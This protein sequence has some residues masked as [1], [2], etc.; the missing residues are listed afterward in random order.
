MQRRFRLSFLVL[1]AI[2]VAFPVASFAV[3]FILIPTSVDFGSQSIRK[4]SAAQSIS[5]VDTGDTDLTVSSIS[6]S[7]PHFQLVDGE[8]P[9]NIR[10]SHPRAVYSLVFAPD[11]VASFSGMFTIT[12]DGYAPVSVPLSGTGID[13]N[14]VIQISPSTITFA[15]QVAGTT[16][17]KQPVTITNT[18]TDPVQVLSVTSSS[19]FFLQ[20]GFNAPV[21]LNPGKT[22]KLGMRFAPTAETSY[23][24]V[25]DVAYDLLPDSGVSL[26]GTGTQPGV[27]TVTSP[28]ALPAA[29][30]G[31]AYLATLTAQPGGG[32]LSWV[33]DKA[34]TLPTGLSL[35]NAG[36]ISGT[37]DASVAT[38]NYSFTARVRDSVARTFASKSVT[39]PVIAP[40]GANCSNISVDVAGTS[41]P[42]L[43]LTDLGT[44]TYLGSE[45][46]LYPDGTNVRPAD[47]DAAGISLANQIQP[48]DADGNPDP[49][50][51]EAF[52]LLGP[53]FASEVLSTFLPIASADPA[54]NPA[55]VIVD[56]ALPGE[57]IE[58]IANPANEYW[59][60]ILNYLIPNAGVTA[61]Q[62]QAVWTDEVLA[63][64]SGV[65][66]DDMSD[67]LSDLRKLA[68]DIHVF[69]PNAKLMY[70]S[71]R[72]YTGYSLGVST[73]DP[74]P[75]AYESGFAVKWTIEDQLDGDP[76]LNFDSTR[77]PVM[78]PWLA[79]GPYYWT[80]GLLGRADG[81]TASCDDYRDDG[82][83]PSDVVG[84]VKQS[85][86]LIDF[87]KS[88]TTTTPWYLAH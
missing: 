66:P 83:H 37:L 7:D 74:E 72:V 41:T 77:G 53:S 58:T 24:G 67:L 44:G 11:A 16:S 57:T 38:G 48:L 51:K 64:P 42:I 25:L 33:L 32:S 80:N 43:A 62:V 73:Q 52:L 12:I 3:P 5:I 81:L 36:V 50:G 78:A 46:G 26:A 27:L 55:L 34:S 65:F 71:S 22:L 21:I 9:K 84:R 14:A 2:A 20:S 15:D 75:Y 39:I 18:G 60:T 17:L 87:F 69:F 29:V 31:A 76:A 56:G 82:N 59:N 13:T 8:V 86:I 30:P 1:T 70:F 4:K 35:T 61:N 88:D 40:T 49:D 45:G 85:G 23:N 47:H 19:S 6:I 79:W 54:L 68:Q 63:F 28:I 10:T